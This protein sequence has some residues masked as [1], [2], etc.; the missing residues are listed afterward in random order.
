MIWACFAEQFDGTMNYNYV[1]T[2]VS[3]LILK[4]KWLMQQD[5]DPKHTSCTTKEWLKKNKASVL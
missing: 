3:E 5:N 1:R 4:R 2:S